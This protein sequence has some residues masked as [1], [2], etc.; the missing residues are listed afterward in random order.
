M[1]KQLK[2]DIAQLEGDIAKESARAEA[3]ANAKIKAAENQANKIR[4]KSAGVISKL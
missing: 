3:E 2:N 4:T 1:I